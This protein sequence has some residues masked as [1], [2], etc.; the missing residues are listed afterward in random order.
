M[1][2]YPSKK[3]TVF[4]DACFSGGGRSEGLLA[5]RGIK[6]KPKEEEIKGNLVVFSASTGEQT[7]LPCKKNSHGMFTYF[8]M[9]KLQESKGDVNYSDLHDYLE[10]EVRV[11]S[12]KFNNKVQHPQVQFSSTIATKWGEWNF[13]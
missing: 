11:N 4:L 5:S 3:V 13:K 9:K 10:R 12:L 1:T 7:S 2:K 6:I 8:L